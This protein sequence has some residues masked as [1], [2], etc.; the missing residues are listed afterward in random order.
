MECGSLCNIK[1]KKNSLKSY[2][3]LYTDIN[4]LIEAR[5]KKNEWLPSIVSQPNVCLSPVIKDFIV[6]PVNQ[7]FAVLDKKQDCN[8][9][10]YYRCLYNDSHGW[11]I[12]NRKNFELKEEI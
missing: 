4:E 12:E 9:N 7:Y 5:T 1:S 3:V 8:G 6:K 2:V 10:F 11:I